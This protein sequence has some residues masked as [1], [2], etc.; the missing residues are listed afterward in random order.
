A[1]AAA[2]GPATARRI[3]RRSGVDLGRPPTAIGLDEWV[4]AFAA[5]LVVADEPARRAIEGAEARLRAE[6]AGL[7]KHHRT[8]S[9]T[10]A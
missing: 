8:R 6:Q 10:T 5:F 7:E 3:E 4:R 1:L 2:L 9:A